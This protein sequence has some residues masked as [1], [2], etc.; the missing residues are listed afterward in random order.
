MKFFLAVM[1]IFSNFAVIHASTL[2][3]G[4]NRCN[5]INLTNNLL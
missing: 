5:N 1:M 2:Y 4:Q 3:I